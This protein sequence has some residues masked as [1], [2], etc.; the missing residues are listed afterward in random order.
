MKPM[1]R[2]LLASAIAFA[3]FAGANYALAQEDV[4][5][6][7]SAESEATETAEEVEFEEIMVTGSR[8]RRSNF[9]G[10][11]NVD[12][13]SREDMKISGFADM[14]DLIEALPQ[15]TGATQ[16]EQ[17]TNSF[18][19]AAQSIN[20]RGLGGART[21]VLLNGYRMPEY[22][23]PYNGQSNFFNVGSLPNGA[24]ERTEILNGGASA[25]YGSD[26]IAGVVNITTRR[27]IEETTLEVD[28]G[29]TYEGGGDNYN[30]EFFTGKV[31][32]KGS[33]SLGLEAYHQ[34]PIY[35]KDRKGLSSYKEREGGI[36][37]RALLTYNNITGL[38]VD[39]GEQ[40]CLDSN[41]GYFYAD[42]P[43]RGM[44]CG[45]DSVGDESLQSEFDE[46]NVYLDGRYQFTDNLEGFATAMYNTNELAQRGFRL[47]WGG[48]QLTADWAGPN[49]QNAYTYLQ[50]I[51]TPEE[52]GPQETEYEEDVLNIQAGLK[53]EFAIGDN[54]YNWDA[55]V[56][57]GNYNS[58]NELIRFK[59]EKI[60]EYYLGTTDLFGYGIMSGNPNNSIYDF[61]DPAAA[62][63]LMG[64]SWTDANSESVQ[65]SFNLSGQVGNF[66]LDGGEV[67]FAWT[68][69]YARNE[70]TI[71]LDDRTLDQT[72]NGWFALTGTKGAGTRERYATG[73]EVLLPLYDNVELTVA[74]RYDEYDDASSVGGR[75][76]SEVKFRWDIL[77]GLAVR[78][79]WSQSFRAPDMHYLF[80]DPSGAYTSGSDYVKCYA[81]GVADAD[82]DG[83]SIF[84][85]A[86][87]NLQLK[88]EQGTNFSAGFVW[89]PIE[90]MS[91][92]VDYY[93]IKLQ[94]VVSNKSIDTILQDERD[95]FY[96]LKGRDTN[97]AFCQETYSYV[98][99]E[100]DPI[101]GEMD[102]LTEV[103]AGPVNQSALEV[104]SLDVNFDYRMDT[105]TL[106]SFYFLVKYTQMLKD[107]EQERDTDDMIDYVW[108]SY[109]PRTR[110]TGRVSWEP[111]DKTNLTLSAFHMGRIMNYD[112]NAKIDDHITFNLYS[113]Y[114]VTPDLIVGLTVGNLFNA[115]PP[116][117]DTWS[118]WPYYYRGQYNAV[119]RTF[120]V[121]AKYTF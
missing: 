5:Q 71:L 87:G 48:D 101:T 2:N 80:K 37:A 117:D 74:S 102:T 95:C 7:P 14:G 25:I 113:S 116:K 118:P 46:Y 66:E 10:A 53:G 72:G 20:F 73:V 62:A 21:L 109:D 4:E 54:D 86:G 81:D 108:Q 23:L 31:F 70:Y 96:N 98:T 50:K 39:P 63:D 103:Y 33:I 99:R 22:P 47:W 13:Y 49:W 84:T 115:K 43:G 18:T 114:E 9:D 27:D 106:G 15:S 34:D 60:N 75:P 51:F 89:E 100:D 65:A 79:S 120:N 38:Y 58:Y 44:Y 36:A 29:T 67:M 76:T 91:V 61:L 45:H 90:D 1:Q 41:T 93:K 82:C 6:A 35:G 92:S 68:A 40:A 119:G 110:T 32:D 77:D 3:T 104:E 57:Y 28:M 94:D 121:A 26:A 8:I 97:S 107:A 11:T 56:A 42:R 24:I 105:S 78:S 12:V 16:G 83:Q 30:I 64:Y 52:T 17:Y 88:E 112:Y 111:N 85:T 19:P 55:V 59:E 69:E